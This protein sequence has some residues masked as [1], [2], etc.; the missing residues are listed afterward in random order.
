MV[1]I[2]CRGQRSCAALWAPGWWRGRPLGQRLTAALAAWLRPNARRRSPTTCPMRADGDDRPSGSLPI[3]AATVAE[4][5]SRARAVAMDVGW[6]SPR[7]GRGRTMCCRAITW[8]HGRPWATAR[9]GRGVGPGL[10]WTRVAAALAPSGNRCALRASRTGERATTRPAV[11][12]RTGLVVSSAIRSLRSVTTPGHLGLAVRCFRSRALLQGA[13]ARRY[14]L[15]QT[16]EADVLRNGCSSPDRVEAALIVYARKR[17]SPSMT[18]TDGVVTRLRRRLAAVQRLHGAGWPPLAEH[19]PPESTR[20]AGLDQ[21]TRVRSRP[22]TSPAI[23]VAH[24]L[25]AW[26]PSSVRP[27]VAGARA[28]G[29]AS[30]SPRIPLLRRS[31]PLASRR[32]WR[33]SDSFGRLRTEISESSTSQ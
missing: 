23:D 31:P 28:H 24:T 5:R 6:P 32:A 27:H 18:S 30:P 2:R 9:S 3:V 19:E 13:A 11:D 16:R 25:V 15:G 1:L 10:G 17:R 21:R 8:R 33:P 7:V 29:P 22:P 4:D 20:T 14:A 12:G 26:A